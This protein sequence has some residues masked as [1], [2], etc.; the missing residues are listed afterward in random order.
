MLL[1]LKILNLN[2]PSHQ[3]KYRVNTHPH[4]QR[5]HHYREHTALHLQQKQLGNPKNALP[6]E[7]HY[8]QIIDYPGRTY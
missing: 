7:L 2:T 5:A 8:L 4:K 6:T 3:R 1:L